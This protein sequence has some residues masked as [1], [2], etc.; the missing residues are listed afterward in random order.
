MTISTC[1]I[2]GATSFSRF[3]LHLPYN[4][5]SALI[6]SPASL[7]WFFVF[8][9]CWLPNFS[10]AFGL[11]RQAATT[12]AELRRSL[13]SS[14]FVLIP[15]FYCSHP[16]IPNLVYLLLSCIA[17]EG[18]L[19]KWDLLIDPARVHRSPDIKKGRPVWYLTN[20]SHTPSFYLLKSHQIKHRWTRFG[21]GI[22]AP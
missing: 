13:V 21:I 8:F 5:I 1:L 19:K 4:F 22:P 9:F 15:S 18:G 12:D 7:A 3:Y 16:S 11:A 17:G 20:A 10:P 6:A 2:V 14:V